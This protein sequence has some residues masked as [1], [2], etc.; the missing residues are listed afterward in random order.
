MRSSRRCQTLFVLAAVAMLAA[1][2]ASRKVPPT[3]ATPAH[4]EFLYPTIPAA[5]QKTFAAEHVDL[6]WRYLQIDDL[7]S[8]EREFGAALKS[9]PKMYPAYAGQGMVALA[10]RDFAGAVAVFNAAVTA[11]PSYVPALVGRGQAL[12]ALGRDGE[13]LASFDAALKADPSL[14]DVRQRAEVLRFRGL[15]DVIAT[16]RAAA[17]S[18]RIPEAR[19][20]YEQ[21]IAGSP[22]SAFLYREL[23]VLER[24]AGNI[25]EALS[26]LRRATELDPLDA[27]A[28][29]Q[30]AELLE[31][32]QDFAGAEAAYRKAVDLDPSPE[33]ESKLATV[34][35][36]AREAQ[37]PHEFRA[38]L[39]A[40]QITRGDLAAIIGVRLEA[41]VKAA[42]ARQVV[43]TDINRHWAASWITEVAAADIMPPFENHTFQPNAAIRRGDLAV[44]VSRLLTLVASGD[45]TLRARI[46]QRPAIADMT[47]GHVQYAAA[48]A[49]VASG[50]MPLLEGNRFQV[51]RPVS[52]SEAADVVD[53]VR[54]LAVQT[55]SA[56]L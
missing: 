53:R 26:R 39:G 47:R 24:R 10:R 25:D 36:S 46:A 43:V 23:G 2:C 15:Q 3:A 27:I 29:V 28:F 31:S 4:P 17:K 11:A 52:G 50:V 51:G 37:L 21:A 16:A 7:R 22:E 45:A 12:L 19:A 44:A 14:T 13:A 35:K 33:L 30:L 6:G 56:G 49:A 54:A 9:N 55:A 42:P 48:A 38:A 18:G 34:A 41:I 1:A 20:A 32:R 8:A 5:M 40:G